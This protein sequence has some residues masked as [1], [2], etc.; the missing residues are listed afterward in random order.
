MDEV[1]YWFDKVTIIINQIFD[2]L[3]PP[4]NTLFRYTVIIIIVVSVLTFLMR[5]W[6]RIK[7]KHQIGEIN[8]VSGK[9]ARN[10]R[11]EAQLAEKAGNYRAAGDAWRTLGKT[12]RAMELFKKGGAFDRAGDLLIGEGKSSNAITMWENSGNYILA[13]KQLAKDGQYER[14]ALNYAKADN[15]SQAAELYEKAGI[16]DKAGE[17]YAKAGF[18]AKAASNF[19]KAGSTLPAAKAFDKYFLEQAVILGGNIDQQRAQNIK[20]IAKR[21]AILYQKA[22]KNEEAAQLFV[23]GGFM[24]E[25]A[26]IYEAMGLTDRAAKLYEDAGSSDHAARLFAGSDDDRAKT[27]KAESLRSQG[28][29]KE[30]AAAFAEAQDYAQAGELYA[31]AEMPREAA[32]MFMQAGSY[33]DAAG[34]FLQTQDIAQAAQAY[35]AARDYDTAIKLRDQIGDAEGAIRALIKGGNKIDA[36]QRLL[37]LGRTNDAYATLQE[38]APDDS[39]FRD[40]C[41]IMAKVHAGAGRTE[42]AIQLVQRGI[43][44]DIVGPET[45]ELYYVLARLFEQ[46]RDYP[47]AVEI[48]S[49]IFTE[50]IAYKDVSARRQNLM[51][52]LAQTAVPTP[53][54]APEQTMVYEKQSG[55]KQNPR[56]KILQE[57]GRGGMG[58]VYK[59]MDTILDRLVA[60]KVLPPDMKNH[61]KIVES[62][63]R[64]AK[65]L[66]QLHH[67][68]IVT[69]FDAG[70]IGGEY[71][72]AMEFVE[73]KNL[74]EKLQSARQLPIEGVLFVA[75]EIAEALNYAHNRKIVHRDI[76]TSNVMISTEGLVK[77]MDFGLAKVLGEAAAG[78]TTVSGTPYYMSPEQTLGEGIDHRTDIYSLGVMLY[79]L[80][81]GKVPF[82]EGDIGYH[83]IHT[84]P[85]SPRSF[86]PEIPQALE[87][88]ILKCMRKKKEERYQT[89][90][91]LLEDLKQV[92]KTQ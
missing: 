84:E 72:F 82:R 25:A 46:R 54:A 76:K 48:Y 20:D 13:A 45:L 33:L 55:A 23:R 24:K 28:K 65:A 30:A 35:E 91:E 40:A 44:G 74:R 81:T 79:E 83:H 71:F 34:L 47:L 39:A 22:G 41:L 53:G 32:Q 89:A 17:F 58:V 78:R 85:A 60:Y 21:G 49:K 73:G 26:Q 75:K 69:V 66:A 5:L 8:K 51:G 90:A 15:S 80:S 4:W 61:P 7:P 70:G 59:A 57:L 43:K 18:Y 56:Y 92:G 37:K 50:N 77:L 88:I 31:Q 29:I 6:Q 64:E 63:N 68:N 16:H 52:H 67:P 42:N 14:S 86:R 19:Q 62:F 87:D 12:K 3:P 1:S 9:H 36:A 38:I 2:I 10:I 11:R 27:L